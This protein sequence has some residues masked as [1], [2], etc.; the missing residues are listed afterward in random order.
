MFHNTQGNTKTNNTHSKYNYS[1]TSTFIPPLRQQV[2][3]PHTPQVTT[4]ATPP[5]T[6]HATPNAAPH[7]TTQATTQATTPETPSATP[8]MPPPPKKMRS[9]E[10]SQYNLRFSEFV[11]IED[12]AKQIINMEAELIQHKIRIETEIG[13]KIKKV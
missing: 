11:N 2:L 5:A 4:Q 1:Y 13:E 3:P 6:Q 12:R 8:S 9:Y 10:E 7:A